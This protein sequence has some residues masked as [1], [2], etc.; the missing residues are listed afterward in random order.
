MMAGNQ[1][2]AKLLKCS[3]RSAWIPYWGRV[4]RRVMLRWRKILQLYLGHH[5]NGERIAC[6]SQP[7][8]LLQKIYP[9]TQDYSSSPNYINQVGVVC[10]EWRGRTGFTHFEASCYINTCFEDAKFFNAF[11]IETNASDIRVGPI[12]SQERCL[13]APSNQAVGVALSGKS[14]Y[15]QELIA[16]VLA[17]TKW[18]HYLT[19]PRCE[20][21]MDHTVLN[22]AYSSNTWHLPFKTGYLNWRDM[23][24][25]LNFTSRIQLLT[26]Y[27]EQ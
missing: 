11:P 2:H 22:T 8:G 14:M 17:V 4:K 15:E 23:S 7:D 12:F 13:L 10:L 24:L 20:A 26:G 9:G 25:Q 27:Q 18:R 16:I 21:V 3:F 19:G 6:L 5:H 1:L